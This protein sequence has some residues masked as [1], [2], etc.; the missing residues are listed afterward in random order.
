MVRIFNIIHENGEIICDY[1]PETSD[2]IGHI[3]VDDTSLEVKDV[4][5]SEYEYGKKMYVS[6]VRAKLAELL[7]SKAQIP[8]EI[9]AVWY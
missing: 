9:C 1:V 4:K 7:T 8:K 5:Y 2:S 3:V 6:H